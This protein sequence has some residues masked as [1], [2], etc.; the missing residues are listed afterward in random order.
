MVFVAFSLKIT[1]NTN[2][3]LQ[4]VAMKVQTYT[5]QLYATCNKNAMMCCWSVLQF[6]INFQCYGLNTAAH[7]MGNATISTSTSYNFECNVNGTCYTLLHFSATVK[8]TVVHLLIVLYL[9]TTSTTH[10]NHQTR[11]QRAKLQ[12]LRTAK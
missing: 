2:C 7:C 6:S 4:Q 11:L 12:Q 3:N 9:T 10:T 1:I 5:L 8:H